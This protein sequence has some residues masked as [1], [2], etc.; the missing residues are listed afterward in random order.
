MHSAN[1]RTNEK[2][3]GPSLLISIRM[4]HISPRAENISTRFTWHVQLAGCDG[5]VDNTS[6]LMAVR[7]R[8]LCA[9]L[10]AITGIPLLVNSD[11]CSRTVLLSVLTWAHIIRII[12]D[13]SR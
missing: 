12:L 2:T 9:V 11:G 6:A 3:F 5:D 10:G 4:Q 8:E 13:Y 7:Q 1:L